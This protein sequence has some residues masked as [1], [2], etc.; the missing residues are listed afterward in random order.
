MSEFN[1]IHFVTFIFQ[2]NCC[3]AIQIHFKVIW[4]G[5]FIHCTIFWEQEKLDF[6]NKFQIKLLVFILSIIYVFYSGYQF[7]FFFCFFF[8]H[9]FSNQISLIII[10]I[11]IIIFL[12]RRKKKKKKK[13][14]SVK[15]SVESVWSVGSVGTYQKYA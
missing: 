12:K 15:T 1:I 5:C 13:K 10:I 9:P 3:S 7:L 4:C 8:P 11:I 14:K 6:G 2:I